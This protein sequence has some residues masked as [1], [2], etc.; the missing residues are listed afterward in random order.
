MVVGVR[1]AYQRMGLDAAMITAAFEGIRAAGFRELEMGWVGD[2]NPA[3]LHLLETLCGPPTKE[4]QTLRYLFD[5]SAPAQYA[6]V[7]GH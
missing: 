1:P 5:R 6:P 7:I 4:H 3:M 2:F